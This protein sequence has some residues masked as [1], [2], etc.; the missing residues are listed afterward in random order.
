MAKSRKNTQKK[1]K[2]ARKAA[3]TGLEKAVGE[4]YSVMVAEGLIEID[5]KEEGFRLKLGRNSRAANTASELPE[6]SGD[7]KEEKADSP[8]LLYIHSPMNGIFYSS[9]KPSDPPYVKEKDV[10][11]AGATVCII[12]AMKLMNEVQVEKNC[13][14]IKVLVKNQ[15]AVKVNQPLFQIEDAR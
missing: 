4:L 9:P 11:S 1:A 8:S 10:I 15:E 13:K 12:E 2:T 5:W 6:Q 3:P 7:N 14:I